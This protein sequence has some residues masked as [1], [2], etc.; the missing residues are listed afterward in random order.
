MKCDVCGEWID[1]PAHRIILM[2]TTHRQDRHGLTDAGAS[3]PAPS[4]RDAPTKPF[5][6]VRPRVDEGVGV[7]AAVPARP[8][9]KR[10][11]AK[12]RK[13]VN[14]KRYAVLWVWL[15]ILAAILV[16]MRWA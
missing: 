11:I 12:P 8:Q 5:D 15:G 10:N 2:H 16:L 13:P 7:S 4:H 6:P 3:P 9:V 1:A 14:V